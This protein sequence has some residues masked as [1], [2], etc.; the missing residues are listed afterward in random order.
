MQD[1]GSQIISESLDI[2][3]DYKVLDFHAN[4]GEMSMAISS[5]MKNKGQIFV[6]EINPHKLMQIK[7]RLKQA[8]IHN[9]QFFNNLASL[10][11]HK[12]SF[13]VVYIDAPCSGK[14]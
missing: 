11:K 6:N 13:D 3:P 4:S 2:S 9:V 12:S 10:E 5:R 7:K 14:L 8:E 1:I